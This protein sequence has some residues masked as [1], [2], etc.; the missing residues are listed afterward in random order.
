MKKIIIDSLLRSLVVVSVI[1]VL[2]ILGCFI[3]W[4]MPDNATLF[5][6]IRLMV[7]LYVVISLY[8]LLAILDE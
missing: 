8:Q 7:S 3:L 4:I 1:C 5:F 6:F 2:A